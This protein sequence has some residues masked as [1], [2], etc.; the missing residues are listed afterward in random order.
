M[1][2]KIRGQVFDTVKAAAEHFGVRPYAVY[3]AL[4]R[5]TIETLGLGRKKPITLCG[6]TF[7]SQC[8]L[9]R[10]LGLNAR[11]THWRIKDSKYGRETLEAR[12]REKMK[13]DEIGGK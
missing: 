11:T 1:K 6:R 7:E 5:G 10:Y 12:V 8:E 3:K 13:S 2:V 4:D 9:A